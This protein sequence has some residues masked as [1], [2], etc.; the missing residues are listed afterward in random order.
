[1]DKKDT[2]QYLFHFFSRGK[3]W[4]RWSTGIKNLTQIEIE[5]ST[6]QTAKFRTNEITLT[7]I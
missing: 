7:E 1:M 5:K 2:T 4:D 3:K 6:I